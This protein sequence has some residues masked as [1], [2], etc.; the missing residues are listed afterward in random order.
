MY[1][2][3]ERI[4]MYMLSLPEGQIQNEDTIMDAVGS[5][6]RN[7]PP[8][9]NSIK[10][11]IKLKGTNQFFIDATAHPDVM[12]LSDMAH[13][14]F[15][16]KTSVFIKIIDVMDAKIEP[17]TIQEIALAIGET[18]NTVMRVIRNNR[19]WFHINGKG[20][21]R[22]RIAIDMCVY[23]SDEQKEFFIWKSKGHIK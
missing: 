4:V 9:L 5:P 19:T 8:G 13:R 3:K 15:N 20:W 6:R 22:R 2:L 7:M 12:P 21:K 10:G 18:E 16:P 17:W 14:I 11:M 1:K 23:L